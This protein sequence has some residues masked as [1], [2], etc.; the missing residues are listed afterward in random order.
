MLLIEKI[1]PGSKF[2]PKKGERKL[3]FQNWVPGGGTKV[4]F[5][6]RHDDTSIYLFYQ[7]EE[8]EVRAV[9]TGFNSPVWEDSCVE[10]FLSLETDQSHYYNFEINA[11]GTILGAYG[12]DRNQR[13]W[14]PESLLAKVETIPS[15]GRIPFENRETATSWNIQVKI[16]VEVLAHSD[17]K[18]LSGTDGYGNFY[19]CGDKLKQPHFLSWKPVLTSTPDFHTPHYFGHLSFL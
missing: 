4:A 18:T 12:P 13:E 1:E 17:I 15:L 9:N 2:S 19:K 6:I 16:P 11:I 3:A 10:F 7:V 14:L 5:S 8:K